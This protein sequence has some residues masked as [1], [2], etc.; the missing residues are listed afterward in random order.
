M[1]D[2][3]KILDQWEERTSKG[4]T[5]D[6]SVNMDELLERYPPTGSGGAPSDVAGRRDEAG[7]PTQS[8]PRRPEKVRVD[9]SLDLHGYR[10]EEA[11]QVTGTFIEQAVDE[12]YRKVVIIHGKG[13]NGQGVLRREIR[14]YLEHHPLTGAM[15]YNRGPEGG[16]GALWVML[17]SNPAG[18]RE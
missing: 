14:S 6:A 3:G 16:R 9:A 10:L 13:E 12:G 2:F 8:R 15:G 5:S 11:L 17:R 1:S 4:A 18:Q 7:A